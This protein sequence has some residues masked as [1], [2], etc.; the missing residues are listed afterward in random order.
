M[1]FYQQ[2]QAKSPTK[3]ELNEKV[4]QIKQS[5][6]AA[7]TLKGDNNFLNYIIRKE[8]VLFSGVYSQIFACHNHQEPDSTLI[9]R[10]YQ[11]NACIDPVDDLYLKILRFV[12]RKCPDIVGTFDIFYDQT[13][14]IYLFQ[15]L[16]NRGN[17]LE[18]LKA[19]TFVEPTQAIRWSYSIW[20][21]MDFLGNCGVVH[22]GI[23]PKHIMLKSHPLSGTLTAKLGSFRDAIIYWNHETGTIMNMEK[24]PWANIKYA[25]FQ[26][27]ESFTKIQDSIDTKETYDPIMADIWSFGA[28]FF[29]I[30]SRQYPYDLYKANDLQ[31]I[32]QEIQNRIN[33]TT[34]LNDD[35][36]KWFTNLLQ[37]DPNK[38][39]QFDDIVQDSW[40]RSEVN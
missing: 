18:Y 1:P 27:P 34:A 17:C 16:A 33:T 31:T 14:R 19:G 38:R 6:S 30:I 10:M 2:N 20:N 37:V 12:G 40:F 3:E 11:S 32:E 29:Y 13:R 39:I 25:N 26:A 9:C 22:R 7:E 8:Q 5:V 36:K 35:G 15:E 21:A 23:R 24:R 4:K 28:T